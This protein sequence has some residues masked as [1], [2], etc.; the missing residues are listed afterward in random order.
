M[1]SLGTKKNQLLFKNPTFVDL[2]NILVQRY[3]AYQIYK[4]STLL[5]TNKDQMPFLLVK[6]I[7]QTTKQKNIIY[8]YTMLS[9]KN[10]APN[11]RGQ[12]PGLPKSAPLCG[13]SQRL[14]R[15][16]TTRIEKNNPP[17]LSKTKMPPVSLSIA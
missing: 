16:F 1:I 9:E 11:S 4:T 15:T 14:S 10:D 2:H 7:L 6:S 13:E 5:G 8:I 17:R 3:I 12:T